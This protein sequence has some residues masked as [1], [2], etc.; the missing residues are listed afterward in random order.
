MY[1]PFDTEKLDKYVVGDDYLPI[2]E[3]PSLKRFY[4]EFGFGMKESFNAYMRSIG[5]MR[6]L[7][8]IQPKPSFKKSC[9]IGRDP[10]VIWSQIDDAIRAMLLSRELALAAATSEYKSSR[11]FF[12]MIRIDFVIDED[13]NVFIMEVS[14][15]T[16]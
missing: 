5:K 12:E 15:K 8:L 16:F 1:H 4:N 14:G 13:L 11:N 7:K 10:R 3:V 2:W 6:N 9:I